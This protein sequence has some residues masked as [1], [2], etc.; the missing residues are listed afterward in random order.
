MSG[1]TIVVY[2]TL[3][4]NYIIMGYSIGNAIYVALSNVKRHN[5]GVF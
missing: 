1:G 5:W 2:F 3:N 4:I